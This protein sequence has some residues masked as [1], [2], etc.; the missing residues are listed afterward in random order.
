[1]ATAV[2][3]VHGPIGEPRVVNVALLLTAV[4]LRR[5]IDVLRV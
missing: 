4:L 5:L 1:M 3:P 2:E